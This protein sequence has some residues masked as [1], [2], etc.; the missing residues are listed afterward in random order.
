MLNM[1]L[2]PGLATRGGAWPK[3]KVQHI[4]RDY[5]Q[6]LVCLKGPRTQLKGF[7]WRLSPLELKP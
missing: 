1:L 7:S 6:H 3:V 5:V 4:G 2:D